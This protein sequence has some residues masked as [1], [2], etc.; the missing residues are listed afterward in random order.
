MATLRRSPT[1]GGCR[2]GDTTSVSIHASG[3]EATAAAL[4]GSG[5]VGFQSTPPGGRRPW[6]AGGLLGRRCFNPR[7]RGGGDQQASAVTC[8]CHKF[9][10]TPPGGRRRQAQHCAGL[11]HRVSIHA[12][13]GEATKMAG[14]CGGRGSCFNPR[15]RGGGDVPAVG[16]VGGVVPFQS[17]PPGGRRQTGT[18]DYQMVQSF[19][20]R[21]RG[22]G[23][24]Q[25]G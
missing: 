17:T 3:G 21:L 6:A 1:A 20:P 9:Q 5:G 22:G 11:P 10:S 7:L 19:N 4:C 12:S 8:Y 23:D 13:G 2:G 14:R 25:G 15:L 16:E 24:S 18:R